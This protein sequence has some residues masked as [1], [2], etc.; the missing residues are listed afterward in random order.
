MDKSP[1]K[2]P[3]RTGKKSLEERK[4]FKEK[5]QELAIAFLAEIDRTITSGQVASMADSTGGIRIIWSKKLSSTAGRANWRREIIRSKNADGLVPNTFHRHHASI[6]LAEKVI[7]NEGQLSPNQ[8]TSRD[9]L[10]SF[11]DRLINV[12]AH[13]YCHLANFMINGVKDNP[14]GKDFKEW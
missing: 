7:D 2:S 5:K 1:S 11:L 4:L 8:T 12:I 3:T 9:K 13:E 6:E 14:H 10:T